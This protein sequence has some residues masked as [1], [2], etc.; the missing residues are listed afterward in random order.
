MKAVVLLIATTSLV[1]ISC[2]QSDNTGEKA[3]MT[4]KVTSTQSVE[5]SDS[6]AADTATD[7]GAEDTVTDVS[8]TAPVQAAATVD[9]E[10]VYRKSCASCHM[11]G[12]AGAPKTGDKEAWSARMSKGVDALVQS[13]LAGVPDT[14]MMPRGACAACSDEEIEAAVRYMTEQSR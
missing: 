3:E 11:T 14:A 4:E 6:P 10:A 1:L 8:E 9:G 7:A 13:A 12:A 5:V 2:S